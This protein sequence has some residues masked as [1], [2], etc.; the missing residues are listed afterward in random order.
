MR[1]MVRTAIVVCALLVPAV[2]FAQR[3]PADRVEAG[4]GLRWSSPLKFNGVNA[5]EIAFGGVTRPLFQS[6]SELTSKP[7]LE[8]RIGVRLTS[9]LQLEAA[10]AYGHTR[11]TTN[12]T[13]D[14][15][16]A[17]AI[18]SEPMTQY[19][20]EGGLLADLRRWRSG[21]TSPFA[22][23]GMAYVRRLHDGR[24]L[25]E[26]GL[27]PYVGG[28]VRVLLG[29]ERARRTGGMGIRAEARGTISGSDLSLD[30]A[31]HI[32]PTFTA[33]MFFRF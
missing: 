10:V 18:V 28:G 17:G 31:R 12:I 21:R 25:I 6:T 20:F 11:L 26:T 13:A 27:S 3:A 14:T 4:G 9:I 1:L 29:D 2:A 8:G 22:T 30:G 7:G 16:T 33:G 5:N 23:G 15:E 24:T 32:V 19:S